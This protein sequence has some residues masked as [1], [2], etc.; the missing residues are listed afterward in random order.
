MAG[1]IQLSFRS[2]FALAVLIVACS[3]LLASASPLAATRAKGKPFQC[4]ESDPAG[5]TFYMG[6][7]TPS[8]C[9]PGTVCRYVPGQTWSP[10]VFP[11]AESAI[12][13]PQI[14]ATS[15]Q[16]PVDVPA[17]PTDSPIVSPAA[18]SAEPSKDVPGLPSPAPT[19]SQVVEIPAEAPT[20]RVQ[21][22]P[23]ASPTLA[24]G[25]ETPVESGIP[26]DD[27]ECEETEVGE[28]GAEGVKDGED[29]LLA[30]AFPVPATNQVEG[31]SFQCD[32]NDA[33][34]TRYTLA[35]GSSKLCNPGTV[36]NYGHEQD[37]P[38]CV[39]PATVTGVAWPQISASTLDAPIE[40]A[41]SPSA[42]PTSKQVVEVP[43]EAA[44]SNNSADPE[45][46]SAQALGAEAP[47]GTDTEECGEEG[48]EGAEGGE[49]G[50]E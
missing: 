35:D 34:R 32:V 29:S 26:V 4:D 12:A 13:G 14:P 19:S 24:P 33:T 22:D 2:I 16:S 48:E 5:T 17:T 40:I 45:A 23:E 41:P 37:G 25:A 3:S 31:T 11:D 47:A 10:C 18:P 1:K 50:E 44:T 6:D 7:G 42:A 21:V 39:D 36:C 30:S 27:E 38:P 49:D 20:T 15:S 46:S 8:Q 28:E 43:A 9:A